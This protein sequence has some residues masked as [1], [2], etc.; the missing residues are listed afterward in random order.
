MFVKDC[1]Q[2]FKKDF[3]QIIWNNDEWKY[4]SRLTGELYQVFEFKG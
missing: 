2:I 1:I 3:Q 4:R